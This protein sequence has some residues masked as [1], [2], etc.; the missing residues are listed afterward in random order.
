MEASEKTALH[1]MGLARAVVGPLPSAYKTR[2]QTFLVRADGDLYC[3]RQ[4]PGHDDEFLLAGIR[5]LSSFEGVPRVV[6]EPVR[7]GGYTYLLT[8]WIAGARHARL[9]SP[10]EAVRVGRLL[11]AFHLASRGLRFKARISWRNRWGRFP[12]YAQH[13]I[14][15]VERLYQKIR[16]HPA[17]PFDAEFVT[18]YPDLMVLA[19]SALD[20]LNTAPYHAAAAEAQHNQGFVHGD[21]HSG[22]ILL[23]PDR[24][25]LVDIECWH[26]EIPVYDLYQLLRTHD[27]SMAI[28]SNVERAYGEIN[29][30][31]EIQKRALKCLCRF[32][33][34]PLNTILGYYKKAHSD[35]EK[36]TDALKRHTDQAIEVNQAI[37]SC[38]KWPWS[39]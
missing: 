31:S 32:P 17:T 36:W 24:A 8:E 16:Q 26:R 27:F 7:A 39:G 34:A 4:L 33:G 20:N 10:D 19:R 13:K 21:V 12:G 2:P 14:H 37:D 22:N 30:L 38:D 15:K 25:V 9:K 3:L 5:H 18:R 23:T 35:P 6:R 11:A 28:F 1:K 29:V